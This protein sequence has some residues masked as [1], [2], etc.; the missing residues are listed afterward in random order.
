[1]YIPSKVI[2]TE[3]TTFLTI[4][5]I[6]RFSAVSLGIVRND[7]LYT[8][9]THIIMHCAQCTLHAVHCT[10]HA[11]HCTLNIVNC[12]LHT[13]QCKLNTAQVTL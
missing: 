6:L 13:V 1:M 3:S 9:H 12:T 7:V 4:I 8:T 5:V 11:V 10:I 2:N